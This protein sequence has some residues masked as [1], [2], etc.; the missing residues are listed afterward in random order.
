MGENI[1]FK[2]EIFEIR[3]FSEIKNNKEDILEF[4]NE[5]IFYSL[6]ENVSDIHIESKGHLKVPHKCVTGVDHREGNQQV[7]ENILV[8]VVVS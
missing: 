5:L 1:Y 2:R 8:I 3:D 6:K 4:L 7:E